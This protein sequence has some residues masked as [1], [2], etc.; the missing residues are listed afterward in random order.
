MSSSSLVAVV[1][2]VVVVVSQGYIQTLK[3]PSTVSEFRRPT[4]REEK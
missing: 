3:T 4:N 1:V 2:V